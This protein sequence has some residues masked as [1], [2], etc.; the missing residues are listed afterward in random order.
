MP[1]K[2]KEVIEEV[3]PKQKGRKK[4]EE[5]STRVKNYYCVVDKQYTNA[6]KGETSP[7]FINIR[8]EEHSSKPSNTTSV[9]EH[10]TIHYSWFNEPE[11]ARHF[12]KELL[13]EM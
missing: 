12:K 10:A 9:Y 3:T 4:K 13:Q 7:R 8:V 2:K 1:R 6:K 5:K 11:E